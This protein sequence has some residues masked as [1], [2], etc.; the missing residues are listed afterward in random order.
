MNTVLL[1]DVAQ[2][3]S[4]QSPQSINYNHKGEGLPLYQGKKDFGSM[5]TAE[6]TVWT[7]QTTKVAEKGDVLI[8]V[9]APVGPVNFASQKMNIGRGLAAIRPWE[10][11]DEKYLYFF[12]KLN[13]LEIAKLGGGAT[14]DSINR[15]HLKNLEIP[16]PNIAMQRR[17]VKKL[18][19]AFEK[20]D[21][22]IALT[23]KNLQNSQEL[24]DSKL[25]ETILSNHPG[26]HQDKLENLTT[27]IGSGAT[28]RGGKASYSTEGIS[29]I[30]SL[31]VYDNGFRAKN[32]AF[33]SEEQAEKLNN[34][35]L[36]DNDVLLNITGASVA[37]CC[38]AP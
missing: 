27:K 32:L 34:V 25:D 35:S 6:P 26:W 13:E 11:L 23:Q 24:F 2:I 31:N 29:L 38:V 5:F 7:T 3:I 1:G 20:I 16:Y 18:D 8:S 14:F 9:R 12:M 10:G 15:N 30:R 37:R 36:K 28:P 22:A 19:G 33:L 21:K 17:V 4:G